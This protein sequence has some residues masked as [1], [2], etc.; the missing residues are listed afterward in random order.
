[1]IKQKR[2]YGDGF[3]L[4]ETVIG[5]AL[6]AL[7]AISI[8]ATFARV[9]QVSRNAQAIIDGVALANAQ[10]EIIRNLSYAQIGTVGGIPSGTLIPVQTLM[11]AGKTFIATT[12]IRNIDL[13]F[14]GVAG[15]TPNDL[16]PAD[17]KLA[18]IELMC[19]SCKNFKPLIL[20]TIIGPKDLE[21]AST[22]GSL[23]IKVLD[24]SGLPI[25]GANVHV[26]NNS[27][28]PIIDIND[29][30]NASGLLQIVDAPPATESYEI[31]VSK[32]GYSTEKTY[33]PGFSP[34]VNPVKPSATVAVQTVTQITFAIDRVA[35]LNFSSVSPSCA[36]RPNIDFQ[37]TG[38]KLIATAP[39]VFKYDKYF[40]TDGEGI[41]QLTDIEWDSYALVA[42]STSYDV[43]G[44]V[45]LTPISIAPG[46]VQNIQLVMV[47]KNSPSVVVTV[48]D[49]ATGLPITGATVTMDNGGGPI[50]ET[51]GRGYLRQTDWSG[52]SGQANY[53]DETKYFSKDSGIDEVTIPGQVTLAKIFGYYT[54][55][56][57]L[58]S[59]TFDTGAAANFYQFTYQPTGQPIDT[60]GDSAHFQ[61]AT[62]NSTSSWNYLGPDGTAATFYNATTTNFAPVNN[63]HRYLRYKIFLSTASTTYTPSVS[64]VQFT[65]TSA[66]VP[67]GQVIFQGL[68]SGTYALDVSASGYVNASSTVSVSV[69]TPW[70]EQAIS[71]NP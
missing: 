46:A 52:G 55:S 44:I 36:A 14:D 4:I 34:T 21:S 35:T 40:T 15:G 19:I 39:N 59:S 58:E 3:S 37:L 20:S 64:D 26:V 49:G 17:N 33:A 24:A 22:N 65:F 67:P 5:A 57:I 42:S 38:S 9:I 7:I 28:T 8:Y 45:P 61:I 31:T 16:S 43:A 25:Q 30:T 68:A 41:K 70:Q 50:T 27:L 23:F 1:M 12:T 54:S 62:S 10:F 56:G 53:L 18:E 6:F 13:P 60:G 29:V 66:C 11:S 71:L 63:G 69:G 32:S 51:T 48:K 2:N 47:P